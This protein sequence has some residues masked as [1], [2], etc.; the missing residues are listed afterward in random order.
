M[1]LFQSTKCLFICTQT[2]YRFTF[3]LSGCPNS[4]QSINR[5]LEDIRLWLSQN[6]LCLNEGKTEC[7]VFGNSNLPSVSAPGPFALAPHLNHVVKNLGVKLDS[8]LKFDEQ[9]DSV[10]RASFFQLRLLSKV[11]PFLSRADLEKAI[12]AFISSR[13][14]YCN[15]L[16]V[17]VHQTG[18]HR[19]QLVQNAAARL[20][21]NG[22]KH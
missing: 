20:L 15:A 22:R 14:D 21:T 13:I 8:S 17:G 12:H 6:F 18:L 11:K 9:I 4:L 3:R 16:Y 1:Q 2:T 10:V 5:C 19:L 7:I